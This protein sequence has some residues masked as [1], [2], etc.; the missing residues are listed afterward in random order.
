MRKGCSCSYRW[1]VVVAI[2]MDTDTGDNKGPNESR[3]AGHQR[4]GVR[5][6]LGKPMFGTCRPSSEQ[7]FSLTRVSPLQE[8]CC[9]ISKIFTRPGL[10]YRNIS[11][12]RQA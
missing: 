5:K 1:S 4:A 11:T 3:R 10:G 12:S 6:T 9:A 2:M 8:Y 7:L